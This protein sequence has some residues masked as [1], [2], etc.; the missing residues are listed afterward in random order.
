[1]LWNIPNIYYML[2][3]AGDAHK[4]EE[5]PHVLKGATSNICAG[6]IREAVQMLGKTGRIEDLSEAPQLYKVFN[7]EFKHLLEH[8]NTL[9]PPSA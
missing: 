1:M 9:S 3:E 4:V 2:L 6:P 7:K 8:L 5:K